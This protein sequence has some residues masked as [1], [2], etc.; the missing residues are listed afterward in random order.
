[1]HFQEDIFKRQFDYEVYL[2]DSQKPEPDM[3]T[4]PDF[5]HYGI[6]AQAV[7]ENKPEMVTCPIE[8]AR[9]SAT[10]CLLSDISYRLKRD[11]KFDT[12][13]ERFPGDDEANAMLTRAYRKPYAVPEKV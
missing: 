3:G 7:R 10:F 4:K 8:E 6:F 11:L 13:T 12:K 1:M 5:D 2:G 9:I